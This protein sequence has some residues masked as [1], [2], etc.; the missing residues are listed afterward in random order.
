MTSSP[1]R[2]LVPIAHVADMARSIEFYQ[3]LGF[4]TRNT[5]KDDD[6][7]VWAW[8]QNGRAHLML[9]R[10]ARPMNSGEQDVFFYLYAANVS[11]YRDELA[12]SGI[13]VGPL[14]YPFYMADGEFRIDDPDGYC[15]LVGQ[16]DEVSL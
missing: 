16:S 4:E 1:L 5:L 13:T 12:A 6:Q 15:V 3:Q 10:S 2:G 8:L 14:T 7:V 11:T 9:S